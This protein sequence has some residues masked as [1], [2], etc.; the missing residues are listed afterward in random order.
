MAQAADK[1]YLANR[2]LAG[3]SVN[4][5]SSPLLECPSDHVDDQSPTVAAVSA[6][7]RR[8]ARPPLRKTDTLCAIHARYGKEAYKC[9]SPNSC[10][11][12]ARVLRLRRLRLLR[13]TVP[14]GV[15]KNSRLFLHNSSHL[16]YFCIP[17]RCSISFLPPSAALL[18]CG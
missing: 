8:Q 5:L 13:E 3:A 17:G 10:K 15:T 1:V 9:Q 6:P 4:A 2:A 16:F 18:P 12:S 11:W 7:P 14:P